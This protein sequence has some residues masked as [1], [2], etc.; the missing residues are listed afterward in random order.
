MLGQRLGVHV[1]KDFYIAYHSCSCE[2]GERHLISQA[3]LPS[4]W[5]FFSPPVHASRC[6]RSASVLQVQISTFPIE[7]GCRLRLYSPTRVE[8]HDAVLHAADC[9]CKGVTLNAHS[10]IMPS[11]HI[12]MRHT[13][14]RR[15]D[16]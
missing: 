7:A 6:R 4:S 8:A 10:Q 12:P 1:Q 3:L 11:L 16:H 13:F 2:V 5:L 15:I 9:F 14:D